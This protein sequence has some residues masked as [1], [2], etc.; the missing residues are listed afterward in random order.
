MTWTIENKSASA[1]TPNLSSS[2]DLSQPWSGLKL[3]KEDKVVA[4]NVFACL[5]PGEPIETWARGAD[6]FNRYPPRSSD[7]VS[8][9]TYYRVPPEADGIE[10]ILSAQTSLLESAPLVQVTSTFADSE[11]WVR[12][13]VDKPAKHVTGPLDF[14]DGMAPGFFLIRPEQF[15]DITWILFVHPSDS[16]KTSVRIDPHPSVAFWVFP[17]SLEKG[18]IRRARFQVRQVARSRDEELGLELL[19]ESNTAAPPLAT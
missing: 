18:V 10:F 2:F 9:Q 14:A 16:Y 17:T 15:D 1:V 11:L 4:E 13:S 3:S 8:Y 7:L 12:E 6:L 5:V 19:A